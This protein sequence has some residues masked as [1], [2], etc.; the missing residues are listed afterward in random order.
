MSGSTTFRLPSPPTNYSQGFF[1]RLINALELDK[2]VMF[3]AASTAT[4][5]LSEESQKM[6]W[7]MS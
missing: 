6:S 3:F 7:F 5:N 2:K 4:R 1:S